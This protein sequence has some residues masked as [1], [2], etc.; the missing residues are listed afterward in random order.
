MWAERRR[1]SRLAGVNGLYWT[2]WL[3]VNR[4]DDLLEGGEFRFWRLQVVS[5]ADHHPHTID[6]Q[7]SQQVDLVGPDAIGSA[8]SRPGL[9][10]AHGAG[11]RRQRELLPTEPVHGEVQRRSGIK[12]LEVGDGRHE[13]FH[14]WPHRWVKQQHGASRARISDHVV[15]NDEC[16]SAPWHAFGELMTDTLLNR[17]FGARKPARGNLERDANG[18]LPQGVESM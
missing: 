2:L 6:I 7:D 9:Q 13:V 8:L 12:S 11:G 3:D 17:A 5:A 4:C 15:D 18:E 16:D 14:R 10:L 1:R